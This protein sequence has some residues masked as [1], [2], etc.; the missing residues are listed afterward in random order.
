GPLSIQQDGGQQFFT[1]DSFTVI[2]PG[3]YISDISPTYGAI[4][5]SVTIN[6]AHLT[7]ATLVKFNT[8]SVGSN[9]VPS[10]DGTSISTYVPAGATTGP[11]HVTTPQGTANSPDAFAIIGPGPFISSFSP[12]AGNSGNPVQIT[13]RFFTGVTNVQFNGTSVPGFPGPSSDTFISVTLPS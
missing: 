1:A 7:S 10:A 9:F 3:P 4:G 11:I 13:G 8:T 2:G 5:D 12:A 6:G